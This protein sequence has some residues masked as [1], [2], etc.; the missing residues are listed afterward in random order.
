MYKQNLIII[1]IIL[2]ICFIYLYFNSNRCNR[3]RRCNC[4]CIQEGF[5][6][7]TSTV[8]TPLALG[9]NNIQLTDETGTIGSIQFPTGMMVIWN[10][11]SSNIPQGW[12]LCDGTL[13]TPDLRGK[14]IIG[15][16]PVANQ[17]TLYSA[18]EVGSTGGSAITTINNNNIPAHTHPFND[19]YYAEHNLSL[20]PGITIPRGNNNSPGSSAQD[21]NNTPTAFLSKTE[22]S[23]TNPN[24]LSINLL[25]V[26][27]TLCYIMKL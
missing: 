21:G 15:A 3:C 17:N 10:G 9:F 14:F 25:P 12:T 24:S 6:T 27:Y 16:N 4:S 13:G 18:K 5:F 11:A 8:S 2:I 22:F 1:D 23:S 26:Y 7:T 19:S 20:T